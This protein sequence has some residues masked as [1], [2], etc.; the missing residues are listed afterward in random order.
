LKEPLIGN[1]T[2]SRDGGKV[3]HLFANVQADNVPCMGID[4]DDC[5]GR[6]RLAGGLTHKRLSVK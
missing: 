6:G 2:A 3:A 4:R 5:G 1:E